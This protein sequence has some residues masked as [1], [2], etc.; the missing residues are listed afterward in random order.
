MKVKTKKLMSVMCLILVLISS[1]PLQAFATFITDINSNANFGVISGS[2]SDYGHELH[3]SDYD[4]ARYM[5]FCTQFG[6]KSPTGKSYTYNGDFLPQFKANRPEYARIAEMIYFG[7]AMNYGMGTP[8]GTDASRAACCTQQYVWETL[9][10]APGRNS[11][12]SNYMSS[13]LYSEWLSRTER[14]YNQYHNNVSFNG[15]TEH[16]VIG[17]KSTLTDRNGVLQHYKT[18]SKTIEGVTFSHERGSNDLKISVASNAPANKVKFNANDYGLYELLPNGAE[19]NNSTMSNYVYI[20]F[21]NGEVQN[22]MFSNYIDPS[23][24]NV[25]VEVEYGNVLIVK[26]NTVGD[27]VGGCTFELYKDSACTQKVGTGTTNNNGELKFERLAT[28]TFYCKEVSVPER[29]FT[30]YKSAKSCYKK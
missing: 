23:W 25:S 29:I 1:L 24:F 10:N 2:L 5:M 7:Y 27:V 14:Y 22:L 20:H 8:S 11:W 16:I 19:Y 28:G 9:G 17:D 26:T 15:G 30:R 3:Y 13:G 21:T 12:N 4:G 18:F 6:I